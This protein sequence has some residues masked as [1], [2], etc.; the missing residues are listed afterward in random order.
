VFA[1]TVSFAGLWIGAASDADVGLRLDV[2]VDVYAGAAK[3][4]EGQTDDVS[5][6]GSGFGDAIFQTIPLTALSAVTSYTKVTISL[7]AT[8]SGPTAPAGIA[9][10]WYNGRPQ[11]TGAMRDAGSRVELAGPA[12]TFLRKIAGALRLGVAG[13]ASK[14]FIDKFVGSTIACRP[15]GALPGSPDRPFTEVGTFVF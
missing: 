8:C 9:R 13:G 10:L 7:R 2:R 1:P 15:S 11:D 12:R 5:G 6:G 14:Q 4:A 3:V